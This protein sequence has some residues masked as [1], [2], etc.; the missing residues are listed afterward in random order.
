MF[1]SWRKTHIAAMIYIS[2]FVS[3]RMSHIAAIINTKFDV[4][5]KSRRT[6][7]ESRKEKSRNSIE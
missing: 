6:M 4:H 5:R 7:P 1:V 2:Q 3:W